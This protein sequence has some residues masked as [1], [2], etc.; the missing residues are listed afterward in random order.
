MAAASTNAL[1]VEPAWKPRAPPDLL[2]HGVVDEGL[3]R[4]L[5]T[6]HGSRLRHGADVA[7]AGLDHR[8]RADGLLAREDVGLD[9]VVGR[10]LEAE[11][12]GRPDRQPAGEQQVL[13]GGGG[14]AQRAVALEVVDDVVAEERRL[15]EHAAVAVGGELQPEVPLAGLVGL[16]LADHVELRHPVQHH[17][18]AGQGTVGV[19]GRVEADGVLDQAGQHGRLAQVELAGVLREVVTGRGL[20]AVDAVTEVRDVEV[21]LEDP[22]LG[23]LLLE[24]D[25]VAE[26]ADLAGEGVLDGRL[27]LLLGL[28]LAQ[29]RQLDHLLGDR[30]ATLDHAAGGLVGDQGAQRALHVEGAVLVE[31]VVLDRDDRLPHHPGDLL[32]RTL[33][34][35]SS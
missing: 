15:G 8:Q 28:R 32:E 11:V 6:A 22:V 35:F 17:V 10:L 34:R 21:T 26:L 4:L 5:V 19:D 23:V 13:A 18:A 24:G 9:R 14:L 30:R 20:D 27:A 33:T 2:G 7:R 16:L 25:R 1:N 29:Q 31:A 12:D 3:A